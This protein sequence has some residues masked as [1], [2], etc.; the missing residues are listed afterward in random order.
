MS[1]KTNEE[2]DLPLTQEEMEEVD[3]L[4]G[5]G[6]TGSNGRASRERQ[7]EENGELRKRCDAL[8]QQLEEIQRR[9]TA[10]EAEESQRLGEF[11]HSTWM[12][13]MEAMVDETVSKVFG[14]IKNKSEGTRKIVVDKAPEFSGS[15]GD[16]DT[17]FKRLKIWLVSALCGM[18]HTLIGPAILGRLNGAAFDAVANMDLEE[19]ID[20]TQADGKGVGITG[21]IPR[22]VV[23]LLEMLDVNGLKRNAQTCLY[24][25]DKKFRKME[26]KKGETVEEFVTAY[27]NAADTVRKHGGSVSEA[28]LHN[29][30]IAA[31][32]LPGGTMDEN[33]I[34]TLEGMEPN[35]EMTKNAILKLFGQVRAVRGQQEDKTQEAFAVDSRHR[36]RNHGDTSRSTKQ[37]TSGPTHKPGQEMTE[38]QRRM[39]PKVRC[40]RCGQLGHFAWEKVCKK[41]QV[42]KFETLL[43]RQDEGSGSDRDNESA[44]E[45]QEIGAAER[46]EPRAPVKSRLGKRAGDWEEEGRLFTNKRRFSYIP[47]LDVE[48]I[49]SECFATLDRIT[50]LRTK[51]IMDTGAMANVCGERWL[52]QYMKKAK[53]T[54]GWHKELEWRKSPRMFIFGAS[55][56]TPTKGQV[57]LPTWPAGIFGFMIVDVLGEDIHGTRSLPFLM[58][59]QEMRDGL[60]CHMDMPNG[61][62]H[63]LGKDVPVGGTGT[64]HYLL[65]LLNGEESQWC[66]VPDEAHWASSVEMQCLCMA[67]A[68]TTVD[69]S[70]N[71]VMGGEAHLSRGSRRRGDS[72]DMPAERKALQAWVERLHKGFHHPGAAKLKLLLKTAGKGEGVNRM[73]DKVTDS[74]EI[75]MRSRGPGQTPKVCLPLAYDF[76]QVVAID[77]AFFEGQP[78]LKII[79]VHTRFMQ[80]AFISDK[81]SVTIATALEEK[82][83]SYFGPPSKAFLCDNAKET[84]GAEFQ[85]FCTQLDLEIMTTSPHGQWGNGICERHGH[86]IN[87]T[88]ECLRLEGGSTPRPQLLSKALMGHN[89][90]PATVTGFSP[91]QLVFGKNPNFASI[92]TDAKATL[93]QRTR[94]EEVR[95]AISR[96]TDIN[97]VRK[98]YSQALADHTL[99]KALKARQNWSMDQELYPGMRVEFHTSTIDKSKR[100]WYGPA[101]V[102]SVDKEARKVEMRYQGKLVRR[103]ITAVHPYG[104][105]GSTLTQNGETEPDDETDTDSGPEQVEETEQPEDTPSPEDTEME[106]GTTR[107][108]R[109]CTDLEA[110]KRYLDHTMFVEGVGT[111]VTQAEYLQRNLQPEGTGETYPEAFVA[112]ETQTQG[113]TQQGQPETNCRPSIPEDLG[114]WEG[115]VFEMNMASG[116]KRNRKRE[117]G[118]EEYREHKHFFDQAI[119]K[120][121]RDITEKGVFRKV[122]VQEGTRARKD[123]RGQIIDMR[124]ILEWKPVPR[125]PTDEAKKKMTMRAPD[126]TLRLAKCRMVAL[127]YQEQN[128]NEPVDA[129][130]GTSTGMRILC[131]MAAQEGWT[132]H[133]RDVTRAFLQSDKRHPSQEKIYLRP[134]REARDEGF[135][136][137]L[138]KS[139]YGLRSAPKAWWETITK[140][141]KT[142]NFNQCKQ[143]KAVFTWHKEGEIAGAVH[144]HVD[145]LLY[146]GKPEFLAHI[147]KLAERFLFDD[148]EEGHFIHLGIEI[149]QDPTEGTIRLTQTG[150]IGAFEIID[151]ITTGQTKHE[152]EQELTNTQLQQFRSTVGAMLWTTQASRPDAAAGSAT[153]SGQRTPT[154]EMAKGANKLVKYLKHTADQ[155]I[156]YHK[157]TGTLGLWC[158][159]DAA[160]QDMGRGG[161]RGGML[162]MVGSVKEGQHG[163]EVQGSLLGWSTARIKRVVSSTFSGELLQQAA[164]FDRARW[165]AL[166]IQE[167]TG[168]DVPLHMRTDCKSLIQNLDSLRL[169][170]KEKRLTTEMWALREAFDM[171][172]I[173]TYEHVPTSFMIADGMTKE[174]A[175]AGRRVRDMVVDAMNGKILLPDESAFRREGRAVVRRGKT[176]IKWDKEESRY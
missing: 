141:L 46:A 115:Q 137:E 119:E 69:D 6:M 145:D 11:S 120:E 12:Q 35:F 38:K 144:L 64:E 151:G 28:S 80:G 170:A 173:A 85:A 156:T 71:E 39:R 25:L 167:M 134:P 18:E 77:L 50:T 73:V 129:P 100:Q 27:K 68:Q 169:Q 172:E 34:L 113:G 130:T 31:L 159:A 52:E 147:N 149:K 158:Y 63:V 62:A 75:C 1:E 155:G 48:E 122:P 40:H 72:T 41:E 81:R 164:A 36:H 154:V 165:T 61:R 83:V 108:R 127:G 10:R 89:M 140:E 44:T 67:V 114:E 161:S 153:K 102:V 97:T 176:N 58:S 162:L 157:S 123:G 47:G 30:L 43:A 107:P 109:R 160:N 4:S 125:M 84:I 22:G 124:L 98:A 78:W 96:L 56:P 90:L 94:D 131:W 7:E 152:L 5:G 103:H 59:K 112:T 175:R 51:A 23:K 106:D 121:I 99:R 70:W 74:C 45:V 163:Q 3:A 82:W 116:I 14:G 136:W 138:E 8:Q 132:L 111:E 53:A 60:G 20:A 13:S 101:E 91:C 174:G 105:A 93:T 37:R 55:K 143:D 126:G 17:W 118:A 168:R 128:E 117:V 19:V 142:Q 135:L 54:K 150:R 148:P 139:L 66:R 21:N 32:R 49:P 57:L 87:K 110:R 29:G 92:L 76:N 15:A 95:T 79:D 33:Q 42:K 133:S 65:E 16:F 104:P 26:R 88:M 9:Q 171:D 166:L 146:A 2:Q 24:D 86:V